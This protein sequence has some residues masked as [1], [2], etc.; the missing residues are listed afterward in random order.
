MVKYSSLRKNLQYV[1]S[2]TSWM[3]IFI[4]YSSSL[5]SLPDTGR[6]SLRH[7][8]VKRLPRGNVRR[9]YDKMNCPRRNSAHVRVHVTF[10]TDVLIL[11]VYFVHARKTA[12]APRKISLYICAQSNIV[13]IIHRKHVLRDS[14]VRF[15]R[16]PYPAI[17]DVRT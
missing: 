12:R 13:S 7:P 9:V 5:T 3:N 14:V 2:N 17:T 1:M 15:T 4:F 11:V 6:S 8:K 10:P 16:S